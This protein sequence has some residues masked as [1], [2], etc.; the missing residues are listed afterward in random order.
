MTV[1]RR[2]EKK[3]LY[4]NESWNKRLSTFFISNWTI[5]LIVINLLIFLWLLKSQN[6]NMTPVFQSDSPLQ[7]V[8]TAQAVRFP[9]VHQSA[10]QPEGCLTLYWQDFSKQFNKQCFSDYYDNDEIHLQRE[11]NRLASCY[12]SVNNF[13]KNPNTYFNFLPVRIFPSTHKKIISFSLYGSSD[14]YFGSIVKIIRLYKTLLPDWI[15]RFWLG[16]DVPF[17]LVN[18]IIYEGAEVIIV[19]Q[20]PIN[21]T[22]S[23]KP[24]YHG[25]FWRFFVADDVNVERFIIRDADS[26]PIQREIDA[27]NQWIQ[28]KTMFHVMRDHPQHA[29]EILGGMWGSLVNPTVLNIT[30]LYGRALKAGYSA[31][32]GRGPDQGFLQKYVWPIAKTIMTCHASYRWKWVDNR[33]CKD[34]PTPRV[35]KSFIGEIVG[36]YGKNI[37][38]K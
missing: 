20:Q 8:Q 4:G 12:E 3:V 2:Q 14:R 34:F 24:S 17:I 5:M 36:D 33:G 32:D 6:Q 26:M 28:D 30:Q 10:L 22:E 16:S 18:R 23:R 11:I 19:F 35:G 31:L 9:D 38:I 15:P 7:S 37:P 1:K 21:E 13:Y 25:M 27:I 29:I